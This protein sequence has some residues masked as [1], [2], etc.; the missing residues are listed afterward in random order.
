MGKTAFITGGGTGL[1]RGMALMLSSLGA[2][3]VIAARRLPVLESTAAVITAATGGAVL[4][5]S[6]DVREGGSVASA[7]QACEEKFG[8]P[9]IVINNAAGNFISVSAALP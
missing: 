2:N 9:G 7:M 8:L 1:G 3:V 5:L 6:M 4:P